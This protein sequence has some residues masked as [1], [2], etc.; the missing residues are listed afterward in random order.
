M[1][2]KSE[3]NYLVRVL[4]KPVDSY[5]AVLIYPASSVSNKPASAVEGFSFAGTRTLCFKED[6]KSTAKNLTLGIVDSRC[7]A[8]SNPD[9]SSDKVLSVDVS[10]PMFGDG[11]DLLLR[12]VTA[13]NRTF[14]AE[15]NP[16]ITGGR[17][18][19][20]NPFGFIIVGTV[21]AVVIVTCMVFLKRKGMLFKASS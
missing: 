14:S 16:Q 21:V 6:P 7:K 12:A 15:S 4:T 19:I 10:P 11:G 5:D 20:R 1:S 3:D 17:P 9:W 13:D 2:C 18:I 8:C